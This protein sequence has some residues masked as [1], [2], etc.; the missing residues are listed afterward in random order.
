[1]VAASEKGNCFESFDIDL[2][3]G[4]TTRGVWVCLAQLQ[5]RRPQEILADEPSPANVEAISRLL[6][7]TVEGG[8]PLVSQQQAH[9]NQV[10]VVVCPEYAFGS[11]DWQLIDALIKAFPGPLILLAGFG[12]TKLAGLTAIRDV[13]G[14]GLRCGWRAEADADGR[15]M[16]FGSAWV[17]KVDGNREVVLYGKNFPEA[18]HEDG[19]GVFKFGELTEL[20]F[21]DLRIFPFICADALEMAAQGADLAVSQRIARQVNLGHK[22]ALCIGSLLQPTGQATTRWTSAIARI[23]QE[24]GQASAALLI[25]NVA[26]PGYDVRPGGELW[27]NLSGVYVAKRHGCAGQRHAQ[28]SFAYF[29]TDAVMAWPLRTTSPQFAFGTVSLPPYNKDQGV[30]HPWAA[31]ISHD[32]YAIKHTDGTQVIP[33]P[34]SGMHDEVLLLTEVTHCKAGGVEFK[35]E[36]VARHLSDASKEEVGV[37]IARLLDGPL[38]IGPK[39]YNVVELCDRN[40]KA[41]AGSLQYLDALMTASSLQTID[42]RRFSWA[43]PEAVMG[44]TIRLLSPDRAVAI[45]WSG[46][47]VSSDM[48]SDLRNRAQRYLG[49]L[50]LHLFARGEDG[51]FDSDL[52]T[53][54]CSEVASASNEPAISIGAE[55]AYADL[56][57]VDATPLHH[58]IKVKGMQALSRLAHTREVESAQFEPRYIQVVEGLKS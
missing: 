19:A 8:K 27:R 7:V 36:Q 40:R 54:I 35:F 13:A 5:S 9:A 30:F 31:P 11:S 14:D 55:V 56:S 16:N 23:M 44:E 45:W 34:R 53:E 17:K 25:C 41:L 33:Y 6:S 10:P 21:D 12:Q 26:T 48:M 22:P 29:E 4:V 2:R 52:W 49:S 15:P 18:E 37:F 28:E 38:G 24:L 3:T 1:M 57:T 50:P 43:S 39:P 47:E 32:R 58:L 46:R 20:I 51:D 42:D